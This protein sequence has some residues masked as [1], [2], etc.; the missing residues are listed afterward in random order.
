MG[1]QPGG[2]GSNAGALLAQLM[3]IPAQLQEQ[4]N[5]EK[6]QNRQ[7][8]LQGIQGLGQ[9]LQQFG[10][11]RFAKQRAEI[12]DA[13][14]RAQ[15]AR[16]A[17]EF[18]QLQ[19]LREQAANLDQQQFQR[20]GGQYT[21]GVQ[22]RQ[23]ERDEDWQR[24]QQLGEQGWGR[25]KEMAG[26][27]A[28]E[29]ALGRDFSAKESALD[30]DL[31]R[32]KLQEGISAREILEMIKH[33]NRSDLLGQSIEGNVKVEGVKQGGKESLQ[34][35][36]QDFQREESATYKEPRAKTANEQFAENFDFDTLEFQ[37]PKGR[38]EF[39]EKT[40]TDIKSGTLDEGLSDAGVSKGFA[41]QYTLLSHELGMAEMRM[42]SATS[43]PAR[44]KYATEVKLLQKK[45][46]LLKEKLR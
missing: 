10:Q 14:Q 21:E 16:Q 15:E 37:D 40:L 17:E 22:R 26:I 38:I 19:A 31:S 2:S 13:M 28:G 27:K 12:E 24:Q 29:S 1:Y 8:A 9:G 11:M 33:G 3:Q 30:R 5:Q 43:D 36:R 25:E 20:E 41:L 7:M 39:T 45:I 32:E 35:D 42:N 23:Q 4:R 44:A 34:E 46:A 6:L 18:S